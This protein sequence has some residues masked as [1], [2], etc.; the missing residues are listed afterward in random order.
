MLWVKHGKKMRASRT[1]TMIE[2]RGIIEAVERVGTARDE[3]V[4]YKLLVENGLQDKAFEAVVLRHP[5]AFSE[6]AVAASRRRLARLRG[7]A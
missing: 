1:W 5:S 4:A 6:A 7:E 3:T 2:K